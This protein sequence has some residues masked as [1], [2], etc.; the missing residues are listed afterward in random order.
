[1]DK[2]L[3]SLFF[4]VILVVTIYTY[5]EQAAAVLTLTI[6]TIICIFFIRNLTSDQAFLQRIFIIG[7]L[8]RV[9]IGL[10]IH[11]FDL[12]EFFGGDANAYHVAGSK[13]YEVWFG[14]V[15]TND[16]NSQRIL[17]TSFQGWGMNYFV[18]II[19]AV[20]G[21]NI[22][23]AQFVCAVV[24]AGTAPMLYGCALKIFNNRNVAKMSAVFVAIFPA[25]VIWSSQLLKDGL[26]IFL[27]VLIMTMVLR[28]QEKFDYIALV[29]LLLALFGI[30]SLRFY[31]FYVV[32][33][34]IV[35]S[36]VIGTSKSQQAIAKRL[37][38]CLILGVGLSYMGATGNVS[39][40]F[41]RYGD[42]ETIQ[43]GRKWSAGVTE[44]GY[45]EDWDVSTTEGAVSVLPIG[46]AYLMFAPFPW[47]ATNL[48]Q[49][50]AV[51]ETML[52]WLSMPLLL[53]GLVYTI[54][55]RLRNAIAILLFTGLLTIAYSITQ[56]NVGT[57]Y[58]QRTQ[59]QVFLFMFIAVG[60]QLRK[61]R[62]ENDKIESKLKKGKIVGIRE[63]IKK[64]NSSQ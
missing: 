27:L 24:G 64:H 42:L 21:P 11:V 31:L 34:A 41:K 6:T 45:G 55:N 19:Y 52:W 20:T 38:A 2:T 18:G 53:A 44:S 28:L 46:F 9:S 36:F 56:N 25:C 5:P 23:A 26:V 62:I 13:L 48:R 22:L 59:I 58:R 49:A 61:E 15:F 10:V 3:A 39:E 37:I 54:R 12:R 30:A 32:V 51:P 14:D 7:L 1:M 57:A 43:K 35:G 17:S 47:Q 8:L 4:L 60:W 16:Y 50:I 29:L 63:R 40:N 33:V